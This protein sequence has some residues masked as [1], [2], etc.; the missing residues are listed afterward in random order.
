MDRYTDPDFNPLGGATSDKRSTYYFAK[1]KS[2]NYVI[3]KYRP[4]NSTA[5]TYAYQDDVHI[6]IYRGSEL[7]FM[8]A[9]A[10]NNLGRVTESSALIN[11]G[12]EVFRMAE[13]HGMGLQ[14][15]GPERVR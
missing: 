15:T 5:R 11:Q 14:M 6:Y 4:S 10:L 1:D 9:E 2:G 12:V 7:Y 13:G 3:Q 8:L